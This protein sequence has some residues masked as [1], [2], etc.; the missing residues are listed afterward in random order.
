MSMAIM[1]E[2][3]RPGN[4][5]FN[6]CKENKDKINKFGVSRLNEIKQ[7]WIYVKNK[8]NKKSGGK[9]KGGKKKK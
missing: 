7:W 3:M 6:M 1:E 4:P 8:G 2:F 9:K 5:R